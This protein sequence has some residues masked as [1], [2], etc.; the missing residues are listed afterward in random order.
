MG[1]NNKVNNIVAKAAYE[2]DKNKVVVDLV[3]SM[4]EHQDMLNYIE[5]NIPEVTRELSLFGKSQS[6]FMDNQLTVSH[7][8][9]KRNIRQVLAELNATMSAYRENYIECEKKKIEIDILKEDLEEEKNDLK[10]KLIK[11]DIKKKVNELEYI[12]NYVSGAIRKMT[13]YMEQLQSIK[14]KYNIKD[15]S[16]K[17]FEE[18]EEAYHISKAFQQGICAARARGG[19]GGGGIDEGNMIY[20]EQIGISG[21]LA[22]ELVQNFFER[23]KQMIDDKKHPQDVYALYLQFIREV[24]DFF[25]GSYKQLAKFKGMT[26]NISE[27]ALLKEGDTRLIKLN[28]SKNKSNI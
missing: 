18:E 2:L 27:K 16:E 13:N 25:K 1:A 14:E 10:K 17:S 4:P 19:L 6:Q 22:N 8:T 11:L 20:L 5:K 24:C 9:P 12:K 21:A 15:F 23:E 26:G 3:E 7:L 28:E